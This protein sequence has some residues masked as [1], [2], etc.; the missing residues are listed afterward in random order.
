MDVL[1]QQTATDCFTKLLPSLRR[2]TNKRLIV[3]NTS[4][5]FAKTTQASAILKIDAENQ[6]MVICCL[7]M[8][9]Y[10]AASG[11]IQP[12]QRGSGGATSVWYMG[13][14]GGHFFCAMATHSTVLCKTCWLLQF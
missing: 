14:H 3:E 11:P 5:F 2:F 4:P 9:V 13:R 8:V 12:D 10:V 7:F 1:H 6:C